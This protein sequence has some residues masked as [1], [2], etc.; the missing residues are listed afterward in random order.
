MRKQLKA[1]TAVLCLTFA[2]SACG[3][4]IGTKF[5]GASVRSLTPGVSTLQDAGA[6]LGWPPSR[7]LVLLGGRK[8]ARWVYL[9]DTEHGTE[10]ARVDILFG[11]DDRMIKVVQQRE[12]LR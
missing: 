12:H 7:T 3:R 9:K 4:Q 11:S 1:A 2:T 6:R 10:S 8:L 5:D